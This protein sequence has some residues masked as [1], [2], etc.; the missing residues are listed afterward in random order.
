MVVLGASVVDFDIVGESESEDGRDSPDFL[1]AGRRAIGGGDGSLRYVVYVVHV[2]LGTDVTVVLRRY[3]AFAALDLALRSHASSAVVQAHSCLSADA[4]LPPKRILGRSFEPGYLESKRAQLDAYLRALLSEAALRN[5]REVS[6]FMSDSHLPKQP[7]TPDGGAGSAQ[8]QQQQQHSPPPLS[9][10]SPRLLHADHSPAFCDAPPQTAIDCLLRRAAAGAWHL[11]QGEDWCDAAAAR[12]SFVSDP[13]F[14]MRSVDQ[15]AVFSCRYGAKTIRSGSAFGVA[16]EVPAVFV[17]SSTGRGGGGGGGSASSTSG[18]DDGEGAEQGAFRSPQRERE[19]RHERRRR[20]RQLT[21]RNAQ[22]LVWSFYTEEFDVAFGATF[23]LLPESGGKGGSAALTSSS[24]GDLAS[25]EHMPDDQLTVGG[26]D[27]LIF[28]L[29]P[30]T[31]CG[32]RRWMQGGASAKSNRPS[33]RLGGRPRSFGGR[34]FK[35]EDSASESSDGGAQRAGPG[36]DVWAGVGA[37]VCPSMQP[38]G[39]ELDASA[40]RARAPS[41]SASALRVASAL[42]AAPSARAAAGDGEPAEGPV[43][44]QGVRLLQTVEG[45]RGRALLRWD[46]SYSRLRG[47]RVHFVAAVVDEAALAAAQAEWSGVSM[48]PPPPP[49]SDGK[50]SQRTAKGEGGGYDSHGCAGQQR[51]NAAERRSSLGFC[52]DSDLPRSAAA[53]GAAGGAARGVAG[54][55]GHESA[56]GRLSLEALQAAHGEAG[57]LRAALREAQEE[58]DESAAALRAARLSEAAMR[59]ARDAA[60]AEQHSALLLAEKA[61][62]EEDARNQE[63]QVRADGAVAAAVGAARQSDEAAAARE[64]ALRRERDELALQNAAVAR[65]LRAATRLLRERVVG[66][67]QLQRRERELH[68]VALAQSESVMNLRVSLGKAEAKREAALEEVRRV[69]AVGKTL[70]HEVQR[71][72]GA[73]AGAEQQLAEHADKADAERARKRNKAAALDAAAAAAAAA[74]AS[75]EEGPRRAS[76][77]LL[78][79]PDEPAPKAPS[80]L[81]SGGS[82]AAATSTMAAGPAGAGAA[83][84]AM[85][86]KGASWFKTGPSPRAAGDGAGS[87]HAAG[88]A[89]GGAVGAS[90]EAAEA[91]EATAGQ[92]QQQQQQQQQGQ[93]KQDG[94]GVDAAGVQREAGGAQAAG[95]QAAS[96]AVA[97]EASAPTSAPASKRE[98]AT[99]GSFGMGFASKMLSK[100]PK[101]P[102]PTMLP[103][104][105]DSSGD[106]PPPPPPAPPSPSAA[107]KLPRAAFEKMLTSFY[108]A[109]A[110]EE[111]YKVAKVANLFEGREELCLQQLEQKYV[112]GKQTLE[113]AQAVA[114]FHV[115]GIIAGDQVSASSGGAVPAPASAAGS[116]AE[117]AAAAGGSAV[118]L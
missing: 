89:A 27:R 96:E 62:T 53:G 82:G 78:S 43:R 51:L 40:S 55:E 11:P 98:E 74:A 113:E 84:A 76:A 46:N 54:G 71:L 52:S 3:S 58:R 5:S 48:P 50:G 4:R 79:L 91:S 72:R 86:A 22:V 115:S 68:Q 23:E 99:G 7:P 110:P 106:K 95:D 104:R 70:K 28:E 93:A 41:S 85:A 31:R 103:S 60:L 83:M 30:Q 39:D 73:L 42:V 90:D 69:K 108:T 112:L 64:A 47:K 63:A 26:G 18:S 19:R 9:R 12:D 66:E 24:T 67:E 77:P 80:A 105:A 107:G 33:P 16:L 109:H 10:G 102:P 101:V 36:R 57:A 32:G 2:T 56:Q 92:Q 21:R 118:P 35:N 100:L 59:S 45:V 116:A 20:R 44:V 6:E 111:L 88:T 13:S 15:G 34:S 25:M 97:E 94:E 117:A 14:P 65:Q 61:S 17:P 75:A 49:G 81:A 38:V 8:Q 114:E 37:A 1:A 87:A 29:V